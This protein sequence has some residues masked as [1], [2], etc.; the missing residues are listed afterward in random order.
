MRTVLG[1]FLGCA[2]LCAVGMKLDTN[3]VA[4]PLEVNVSI[5]PSTDDRWQLLKRPTPGTYTC[6]AVVTDGQHHAFGS[7]HVIASPGVPASV[8]QSVRGYDFDFIVKIAKTADT[9]TTKVTVTRN[10]TLL[11]RQTSTVKLANVPGGYTPV[12]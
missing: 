9:A 8:H 7:A 4:P 1:F 12:K 10:G 11:T 2:A 6:D 3:P 5:G